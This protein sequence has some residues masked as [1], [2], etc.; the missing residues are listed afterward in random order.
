V[1]R[2]RHSA[3]PPDRPLY[4]VGHGD[5]PIGRFISLI[6]GAGAR[7]VVDVRSVPYSRFAPQFNARALQTALAAGGI[8]YTYLGDLLGGRPRGKGEPLTYDEAITRESFGEGLRRLAEISRSERCAIMC[9]ERD[10]NRCHRRHIIARA[11]VSRGGS[12]THILDDGTF[13]PEAPDLFG[14]IR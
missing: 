12:V 10:P 9:A 13:V 8:G 5:H 2:I 1:D 11:V 3:W 7:H 14:V 4:T 6:T